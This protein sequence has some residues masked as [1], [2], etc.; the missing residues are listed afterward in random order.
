[1]HEYCVGRGYCGSAK[2]GKPLHVTQFIPEEGEV[3]ADQFVS[4]LIKAEQLE[5]TKTAQDGWSDLRKIFIQHMGNYKVDVSELHSE[6][7]PVY[8]SVHKKG[9]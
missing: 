2:D 8:S 9:I 6:W 5:G 3:N 7:N 1:M 4:W